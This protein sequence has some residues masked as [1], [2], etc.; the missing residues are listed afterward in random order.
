ML[1]NICLFFHTSGNALSLGKRH[2]SPFTSHT[3]K[4]GGI[5]KNTALA[6]CRFFFF[7]L[8]RKVIRGDLREGVISGGSKFD[9]Q[10]SSAKKIL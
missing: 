5:K 3:K 10:V 6:Q 8:E 1:S 4:S 9:D 7:S 2:K